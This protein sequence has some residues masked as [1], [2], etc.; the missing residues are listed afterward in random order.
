M[1]YHTQIEVQSSHGKNKVGENCQ[2]QLYTCMLTST[3]GQESDGHRNRQRPTQGLRGSK[4]A[5]PT[6]TETA[7]SCGF[8]RLADSAIQPPGPLA[9]VQVQGLPQRRE[10]DPRLVQACRQ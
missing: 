3:S 7:D 5:L 1:K 8:Q 6:L 9:G 10:P 2:T 4:I